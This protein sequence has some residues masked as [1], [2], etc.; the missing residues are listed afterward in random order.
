MNSDFNDKTY[1][2][3][4]VEANIRNG[5]AFQIRA[6]RAHRDWSQADLGARSGKAQNVIS[7]LEDPNYGKFTIQSLVSLASAFD[8]ALSI[9][10]VSYSDLIGQ[11]K[12]VTDAD[13]A[14]PSFDEERQAIRKQPT[15]SLAEL[16]KPSVSNRSGWIQGLHCRVMPPGGALA[17]MQPTR[18]EPSFF[19]QNHQRAAIYETHLHP[20]R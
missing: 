19:S 9:R 2:D 11:L 18:N 3:A 8:V 6:L 13:L 15:D 16:S 12:H 5:I 20:G 10:F 4:F 14:V 7:R 17:A 1:R